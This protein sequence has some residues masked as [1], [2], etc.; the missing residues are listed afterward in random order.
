MIVGSLPVVLVLAP[1]VVL[2]ADAAS[3][4]ATTA[5]ELDPLFE[6]SG[7]DGVTVGV[8]GAEVVAFE[9][10]REAESVL[11]GADEGVVVLSSACAIGEGI[12]TTEMI[13]RN[14]HTASVRMNVCFVAL[15]KVMENAIEKLFHSAKDTF[16]RS[17]CSASFD[18]VLRRCAR[19]AT[20]SC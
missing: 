10:S 8:A 5:G 2:A 14:T 11:A 9:D 6:V 1:V 7:V 13:K 18:T 15:E 3:P 17:G 4:V 12:R 16:P 19:D 20:A